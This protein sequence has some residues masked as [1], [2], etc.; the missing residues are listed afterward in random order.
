MKYLSVSFLMFMLIGCAS[1][2]PGVNGDRMLNGSHRIW[3]EDL[4][5][6]TEKNSYQVTV[7]IKDKLVSGI[8]MLKKSGDDWRG[9]L[10]N[11]FGG[12][13]FDFV[14]TGK[15]CELKDVISFLDKWYIRKTLA[16]DLYFLFETDDPTATFQQ[17]TLRSV[18]DNALIVSL[19]RK[20]TLTRLPDGSLTLENHSRHIR[21]TVKRLEE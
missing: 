14:I 7:R 12:K 17:Q 11:E 1:V 19:G 2:Q 8:C 20:K 6:E 9:T 5:S 4:R 21:Y 3:T 18:R 10:L 16:S 13:A 15:K